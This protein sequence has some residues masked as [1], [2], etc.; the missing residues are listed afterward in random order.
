MTAT[1]SSIVLTAVLTL[2][3]WLIFGVLA[4]WLARWYGSRARGQTLGVW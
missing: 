1:G 3:N 2:L 4:H